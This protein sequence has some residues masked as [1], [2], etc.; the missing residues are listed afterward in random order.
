MR[1]LFFTIALEVDKQSYCE[2]WIYGQPHLPPW[3][4]L[5][6]SDNQQKERICLAVY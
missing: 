5:I 2:V 1:F 6:S 4:T 3:V